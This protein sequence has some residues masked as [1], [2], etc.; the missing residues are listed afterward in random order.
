LQSQQRPGP[1]L[2]WPSLTYSL[3]RV[4][5]YAA[6][7]PTRM[8]KPLFIGIDGGATFCRARFR[9]MDG[10][11]L[12]EGEG[13]PANIHSNFRLAVESIQTACRAALQS[14]GLNDQSLQ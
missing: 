4:N 12:G 5:Q 13:G 14:A 8:L 6:L 10:N 2:L 1:D 3:H 7:F 9:D 11:L